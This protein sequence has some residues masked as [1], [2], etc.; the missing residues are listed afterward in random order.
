[1]PEWWKEKDPQAA[2]EAEKYTN[3]IPSRELIME[4]LD[5]RGMPASH[6]MLCKE[7]GLTSDENIE[8]LRRRLRAMQRDGQLLQTRK[9]AFGLVSK[10]DLVQGLVM[11]HRDGYGFLIPQ[12]G[13]DSLIR[14]EAILW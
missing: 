11:G 7:L 13:H 4:H 5:Q 6:S 1:M 2:E 3:P 14:V 8:A 12:D 9:G 10:M